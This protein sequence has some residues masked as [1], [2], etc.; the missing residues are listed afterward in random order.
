MCT[1]DLKKL[2][3]SWVSAQ[4]KNGAAMLAACSFDEEDGYSCET[5]NSMWIGFCAGHFLAE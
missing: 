3:E 1:D 2:F 4:F 5:I